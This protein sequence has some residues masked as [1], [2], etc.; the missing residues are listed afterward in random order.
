MSDKEL[1][2]LSV[3]QNITDKAMQVSEVAK[4]LRLSE[5]H[6]KRLTQRFRENGPDGLISKRRGVPSNRKHDPKLRT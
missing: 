6:V 5:R 1:K 2:R 4:V 3:I